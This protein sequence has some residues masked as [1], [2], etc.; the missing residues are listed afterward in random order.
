MLQNI[1]LFCCVNA[2]TPRYCAAAAAAKPL[3]SCPTLCDPVDGSPPGS[4]VPGILKAR[5]LEWVTSAQICRFSTLPFSTHKKLTC[6][7]YVLWL[8]LLKTGV[9]GRDHIT[10]D[11]FM[12]SFL[13]LCLS[14]RLR[15][16]QEKI[17]LT[18]RMG[19]T[20]SLGWS[21]L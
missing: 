17:S 7:E 1:L 9:P 14:K 16:E 6:S 5:T 21:L 20:G 8:I 10:L 13:F 4:A 3:Q 12:L 11:S 15:A 2:I 18:A 19:S